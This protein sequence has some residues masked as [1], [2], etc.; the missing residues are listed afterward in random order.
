MN[1]TRIFFNSAKRAS[2]Q[3]ACLAFLLAMVA[4]TGCSKNATEPAKA[5]SSNILNQP[6]GGFTTTNE[7]PGF[8]D[9]ALV[10]EPAGEIAY[11]DPFASA[12][13]VESLFVDPMAGIYHVR[14]LWGHLEVDSTE[15]DVTDWTG[16]LSTSRGCEVLRRVIRFEERDSILPRTSR[17]QIEWVSHTRPHN[18]GIAVDIIIPPVKPVIDTEFVWV[19]DSILG[20]STLVEHIDT[21]W[22]RPP[23]V[24]VSFQT[25]P[26]SR[27]FS[28]EELARLDTIVTLEDGNEV[29]FT[30]FKF[31]RF[32]CPKGFLGG[33]WGQDDSGNGVF[34]GIWIDRHGPSG[35]LRGRWGTNDAGERVFFG[36]WISENGRFEGLLRGR[37]MPHPN[38]NAD[39]T[40]FEHAGGWFAGKIFNDADVEIGILRGLFRTHPEAKAGAFMG[41]WKLFC[42]S[43]VH[44]VPRPPIE[45]GMGIGN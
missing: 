10:G 32:D 21:I 25:G 30:A 19:V 1:V 33:R 39:S 23:P 31:E 40:A 42:R 12:S 44:D 43:R 27:T 38:V 36:K 3:V 22:W 24:R 37:W 28:L 17:Q 11:A 5:D 9:P 13:D 45:D 16:S 6:D 14:I 2:L 35:H 4:L 7:A 41:R 8:G 29:A 26:Y 34:S 15:L 20:D 18:D